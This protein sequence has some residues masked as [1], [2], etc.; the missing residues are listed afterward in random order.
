MDAPA[1]KTIIYFSWFVVN[2]VISNAW[3]MIFCC[4]ISQITKSTNFLGIPSL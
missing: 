3:N 2:F 1:V 4:V